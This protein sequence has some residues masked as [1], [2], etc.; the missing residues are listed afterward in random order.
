MNK[1]LYFTKNQAILLE[2]VS[3]KTGMTQSSA[4]RAALEKFAE[5]HGVRCD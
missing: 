1:M 3:R 2:M 4:V 5:E